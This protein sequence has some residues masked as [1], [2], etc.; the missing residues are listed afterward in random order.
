MF[1]LLDYRLGCVVLEEDTECGPQGRRETGE[2]H[3]HRISDI[4][5]VITVTRNAS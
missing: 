2:I 4:L 1:S 5:D 3:I